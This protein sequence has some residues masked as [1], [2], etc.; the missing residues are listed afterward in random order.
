MNKLNVR[1][2]LL[3]GIVAG[4]II[5]IG[6]IV[7]NDIILGPHIEA[8]MKRMGIT[9]PG[10]GF[11]V[12]AVAL[13]FIFGIVAILIYAMMRARLGPGPKTAL[14]TAL[15]LWFCLYAYSGTLN[16]LLINVPPKLILM[17]LAWGIVEYPIGILVGA[18][19][20]R[21]S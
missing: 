20:Y 19:I 15:V 3:G 12:L 8:D 14:L 1:R 21:E 5:N 7:L 4:L 17:I 18:S 11:A 2:V 16:M 6:E 10:A 9:P 13:T